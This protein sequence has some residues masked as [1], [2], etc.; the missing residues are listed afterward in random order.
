VIGHE[1]TKSRTAPGRRDFVRSSLIG[2]MKALLLLLFA[3]AV[4]SAA[5]RPQ[6]FTGVIS[7]DMCGSS[8]AQMRMG[9]TDAA[10]TVACISAHGATYVLVSGKNVYGL[11][12]QQTP[13]RFAG[14]KVRVRGTLD[15]NAKT[16][17]VDSIAA[18]K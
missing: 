5:P 18:V 17:R 1:H 7:D 11:S 15:A 3:G 16:I 2:P 14:Q 4:V 8:H 13:E 6:T 10:C 12:D 9:P